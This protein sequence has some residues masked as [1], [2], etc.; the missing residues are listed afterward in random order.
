VSECGV[1]TCNAGVTWTPCSRRAPIT[2]TG[3]ARAEFISGRQGHLLCHGFRAMPRNVKGRG[4]LIRGARSA[5]H[6]DGSSG[7]LG[8]PGDWRER[9]GAGYN[10]AGNAVT[11]PGQTVARGA[12]VLDRGERITALFRAAEFVRIP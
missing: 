4:I 8:A 1:A 5:T 11:G 7:D 3:W 10:R 12:V 2:T 6:L 9:L